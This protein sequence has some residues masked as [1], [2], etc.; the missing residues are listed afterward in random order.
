M[1]NNARTD[2]DTI[3]RGSSSH[4]STMDGKPHPL[5]DGEVDGY[6]DDRTAMPPYSGASYKRES[7]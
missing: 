3:G 2:T 6:E 4:P 7:V 5:S 1:M